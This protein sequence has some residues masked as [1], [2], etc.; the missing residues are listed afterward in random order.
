M[1]ELGMTNALHNIKDIIYTQHLMADDVV[2]RMKLS[3]N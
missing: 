1:P 3:R 2:K